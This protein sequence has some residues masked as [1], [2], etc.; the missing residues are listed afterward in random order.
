MEY[1]GDQHRTSTAQYEWDMMRREALT[2]AGWTV[3][4]VRWRGL[5]VNPAH[6]A[7]RVRSALERA[8]WRP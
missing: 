3:V 7:D 4:Y 5:F 2:R 1:D 6:T 8:G